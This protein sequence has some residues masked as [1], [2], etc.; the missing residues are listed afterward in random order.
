M[1][2]ISVMNFFPLFSFFNEDFKPGNHLIDLFSDHF[3][4]HP[5]SS[6][7]K[8]HIKKLDDIVLRTLSNPSSTIVVSDTSIKNHVATS[9]SHIYS[10]K[11]P[12]VKTT[13]R[14]INIT[15][16]EAELFTIWCSINQAV[17][18]SN[19]NHIVVIT[20][21]LHAARR[22]LN[23]SVYP[24]Q[25]HSAVKCYKLKTLEL[26]KRMNLVLG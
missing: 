4:F 6:N 1:W 5:H 17:A 23:S 12:V 7:A 20:D 21:S 24:Y 18:C 11:K 13:H 22:I 19:V 26:V 3:Y 16:T 8:K 9:I 10:F 15:T 2:M 25:I 14:A